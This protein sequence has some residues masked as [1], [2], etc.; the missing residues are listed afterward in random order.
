MK[1][2][3]L[4]KRG[5]KHL[6]LR[7]PR[8]EELKFFVVVLAASLRRSYASL[9]TEAEQ[10]YL[11]SRCVCVKTSHVKKLGRCSLHPVLLQSFRLFLS[12]FVS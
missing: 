11:V 12:P 8:P 5:F 9:G 1:A 2:N 10:D 7:S 3:F 4:P 6:C